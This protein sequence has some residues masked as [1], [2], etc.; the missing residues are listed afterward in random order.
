MVAI[1]L[2]KLNLP[3]K[4]ILATDGDDDTMIL[5][6]QN[7][8]YTNTFNISTEFFYWNENLNDFLLKYYENFDILI[9][10]D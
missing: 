4:L 9:A 7:I 8:I 3:T 5:L 2:A 1:L 6:N 10:A